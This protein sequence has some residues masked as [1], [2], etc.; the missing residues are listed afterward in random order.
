M[1]R[2]RGYSNPFGKVLLAVLLHLPLAPLPAQDRPPQTPPAKQTQTPPAQQTPPAAQQPP[3]SIFKEPLKLEASTVVASVPPVK[4]LED[5]VVYNA[6]A[7]QVAEDAALEDLLRKIPGL[8]VDGNRVTLNGRAVEKIL[9]NG[10]LYFGGDVAAGLKNIQADMVDQLRAYEMPSDFA[11]ISGI[12]DGEEVPVLDIKVKKRMMDG[13]QGSLTG[14]GGTSARYRGR[15]NAGKITERDQ[16]SLI[17]NIHNMPPGLSLSNA[18]MSQLGTGGSG[19]PVFH[20]AGAS[21]DS[22]RKDLE[23]NSNIHYSGNDR[24]VER[25]TRSQSLQSSGTSFY[26]AEALTLS[27]SR[28]VNAELTLEW[29]PRPEITLYMKPLFTWTRTDSWSNPCTLTFDADPDLAEDRDAARVN[30]SRQS[31]A[32]YSGRTDA[33]ILLQATRRA[34]K[35]GR[36][37]TLRTQAIYTAV[38]SAQFNDY[39]VDYFRKERAPSIRKQFLETPWDRFEGVVQLSANEP[40]GKRIHL[41]A[42]LNGRLIRNWSDRLL[43]SF[44]GMDWAVPETLS[45]RDARAALP[46]GYADAL[47]PELTSYGV[48]TGYVLTGTVNLRIYRKKWN[49]TL[50]VAVKPQWSVIDY[51]TA[52]LDAGH[53]SG[54]VCY[55]APNLSFRYNRSKTDHLSFSYRSWSSSPSPYNMI[56]VRSGTNPL[57]VHIGNPS[58]KPSFTHR[59]NLSW[60]SS[61]LKAQ[62]GLVL[63]MTGN[64]IQ[65]SFSTS[66]EYDPDTGGRTVLSKNIDGDWNVGGSAVWNKTIGSSP[67]SFVN[68]A[69]F[70]YDNDASYLYNS[71]RKEDEVNTM[72]RLMLKERFDL[73]FRNGPVEVVARV[74]GEFTDERSVLRPDLN[75]HPVTLIA[76]AETT[77]RLPWKLRF[78]TDATLFVQRGYAYEEL[79]RSLC[80]WNAFLSRSVL[81]GKGTIRLAG[82]DML[83]QQVNMTRR[84]SASSRA[85][86]TFNGVNR[87]FLLQFFYRFH[88]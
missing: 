51:H 15:L 80:I 29:R 81:H 33:N 58:L 20:S 64:I 86:S 87:Y 66:T 54:F 57:Y 25:N 13:W 37:F 74:G 65:N 75:Q 38:H 36:S 63:D 7:Y 77:L 84:F 9:V 76:G 42:F 52:D 40:V 31:T 22:K 47:D 85:V 45:E 48:Y 14:A 78:G 24:R 72:K 12:D 4:V 3:E 82:Y 79:N 1:G 27:D 61:D 60:R 68:H 39:R 73:T 59:M 28:K 8:E 49:A 88:R 44:K 71:K 69:S 23:I 55:A 10:K 30:A 19:D 17:G 34:A 53:E 46:A 56:P 43:Y 16:T 18:T 35:R 62:R 2:I 32:S 6:A 50:G 83:G 21:Y 70:H 5:T 41:Q 67:F 26:E 11:R